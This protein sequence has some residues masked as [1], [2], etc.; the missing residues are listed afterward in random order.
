MLRYRFGL[1]ATLHLV[2]TVALNAQEADP[3]AF[4]VAAS[5]FVVA[6]YST[7][8]ASSLYA[9]NSLGPVGLFIAAVVN[10]ESEYRELVAG[11]GTTLSWSSQ[12]VTVG[13]AAADA[14]DGAYLQTYFVPSLMLG[15]VKVSSTIEWYEPLDHRG[16]RQ[17]DVN[18]LSA[19]LEIAGGVRLGG[20][21]ALGL[22]EAQRPGRR[23]GPIVQV[24]IPRGQLY[25]EWLHRFGET[26]REVRIG[27]Q[28]GF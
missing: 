12:A 10:P 11:V 28:L 25:V 21:Y 19:T 7:G 16:I 3:A 9:G 13:L 15:P 24:R 6:R 4:R 18:P 26:T 2:G 23:L 5:N 22:A 14:S 8:G 1:V 20:A 17:L 27:S